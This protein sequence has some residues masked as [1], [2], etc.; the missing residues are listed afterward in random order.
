MS[1][2]NPGAAA[3]AGRLEADHV[4][5]T[6][7]RFDQGPTVGSFMERIGPVVSRCGGR[8]DQEVGPTLV[9][10]ITGKV[11]SICQPRGAEREV[12]L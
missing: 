7:D 8:F 2:S 1:P 10:G 11:E 12:A 4:E 3:P 9:V 5:P 6:V